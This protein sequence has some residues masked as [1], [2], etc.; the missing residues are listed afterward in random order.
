MHMSTTHSSFDQYCISHRTAA[1][2]TLKFAVSAPWPN[3]QL[4]PS[5]QQILATPLFKRHVFFRVANVT[6]LKVILKVILVLKAVRWNVQ[7]TGE[8]STRRC[9]CRFAGWRVIGHL[10]H[11]TTAAC[12]KLRITS[13]TALRTTTVFS[14]SLSEASIPLHFFWV[15]AISKAWRKAKTRRPWKLPLSPVY[16]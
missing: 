3:F 13:A 16:T 8:V 2:P 10:N 1:A 11:V 9:F 7:V 4:C 12:R 5:S 15:G 6:N 14:V